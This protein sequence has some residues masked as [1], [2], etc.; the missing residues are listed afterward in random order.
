[1]TRQ[2]TEQERKTGLLTKAEMMALNPVDRDRYVRKLI[3]EIVSDGKDWTVR[4]IA[5]RTGLARN[6]VVKHL[7]ELVN[8]QQIASLERNL[9]AF[10]IRIYRKLGQIQHKTQTESDFSGNVKF[11]FFS[12]DSDD[13]HSICIQ[14]RQK[15]EFGVE[16][17]KGAIAVD[18]DNFEQF[19]KELHAFAAKVIRK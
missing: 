3:S 14:Q 6:T 11:T 15:D 19:L 16:T 13:E 18:F 4:Q 12:L 1:M 8:Q 9:G 10:R 5:E 2:R 17:V 7:Q